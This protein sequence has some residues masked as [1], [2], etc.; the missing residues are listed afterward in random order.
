[1]KF[2]LSKKFEKRF[3][4][5]CR[6]CE[7]FI[8]GGASSSEFIPPLFRKYSLHLERPFNR[9]PKFHDLAYYLIRPMIKDNK[10]M[11][12]DDYFNDELFIN[13]DFNI[14]KK[15]GYSLEY[16]SVENLLLASENFLKALNGEEN[17]FKKM[18]ISFGNIQNYY[19]IIDI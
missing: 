12:F 18:K 3:F 17:L 11:K 10:Y 19:N 7:F 14:L 2:I 13:E 16:N 6:N 8:I 1:M 5:V 9:K 4:E 15:L